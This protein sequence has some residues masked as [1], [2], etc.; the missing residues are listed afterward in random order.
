MILSWGFKRTWL[1]CRIESKTIIKNLT[2]TVQIIIKQ[3][4]QS[5]WPET[6]NCCSIT[7]SGALCQIQ[8]KRRWW[9]QTDGRTDNQTNIV[10]VQSPLLAFTM[11][12]GLNNICQLRI[13]LFL[14]WLED[15]SPFWTMNCRTFP[16]YGSTMKCYR[17]DTMAIR[18]TNSQLSKMVCRPRR[19]HVVV[20]RISVLT[21]SVRRL[22]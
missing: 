12:G 17:I 13:R 18:W 4:Y 3:V 14:P 20:S 15:V 6:R 11:W 22:S 8:V 10:I 21:S 1:E 2:D 9:R 5:V 7:N 19:C 16:S